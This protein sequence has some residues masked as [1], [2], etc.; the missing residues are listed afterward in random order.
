MNPEEAVLRLSNEINGQRR[1]DVIEG[2]EIS[3]STN[4]RKLVRV[5]SFFRLPFENIHS[6]LSKVRVDNDYI[7][8]ELIKNIFNNIISAHTNEEETIL[9]LDLIVFDEI[10][11]TYEG[12]LSL[13]GLFQISPLLK[14]LCRQYNDFQRLPVRDYKLELEQK[15]KEVQNLKQYIKE[16]ET[17]INSI[18]E[19]PEDFESNIFKACKEGKFASVQWLIEKENVDQ[20][21]KVDKVDLNLDFMKNDTLIH[22][23]SKSGQLPIVK[24]LIS[25][26]KVNHDIKGYL[27]NTPLHYACKEGH[28]SIAE[29]LLQKGANVNAKNIEGNTPIHNACENG[30]IQIV[31]HLFD[32]RAEINSTNN[33]GITPLHYSCQYG[34][35]QIAKLLISKGAII[36]AQSE[37]GDTALHYACE[38]GHIS[39]VKYLIEQKANPNIPNNNKDTPLHLACS[40]ENQLIVEYLLNNGAKPDAKNK[41]GITPLHN[42]CSKDQLPIARLLIKK[43]ADLNTQNQVGETPL[44]YASKIKNGTII[45]YLN[46]NRKDSLH[47][48]KSNSILEYFIHK[49]AI[50]KMEFLI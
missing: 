14:S 23:A 8:L 32:N 31:E 48:K 29:Y 6:V 42:A 9:L 36:N 12:I 18:S 40:S 16:L 3:L 10:E 24:Y 33:Y 47:F 45:K 39:T 22:I 37:D 1:T 46:N 30:H 49:R 20:N 43:G 17:Y 28:L 41:Y 5:E 34:H 2:L 4:I 7:T 21:I 15:E 26:H 38:N 25:K 50:P 27:G 19:K 13:L 35:L 44:D 11:L